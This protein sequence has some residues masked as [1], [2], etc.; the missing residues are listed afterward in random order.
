MTYNVFDYE[1]VA[2][3]EYDFQAFKTALV[4][5][6]GDNTQYWETTI[7]WD[8]PWQRATDSK[9]VYRVCPESDVTYNTEEFS[10]G[11]VA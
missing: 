3:Q 8:S 2:E 5:A 9:W 11:W 10:E 7:A 6:G 1:P 4:L